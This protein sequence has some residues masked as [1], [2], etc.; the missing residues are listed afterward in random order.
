MLFNKGR[1]KW[2]PKVNNFLN[3]NFNHT[4]LKNQWISFNARLI[5]INLFYHDANED[6]PI[7]K[8]FPS[9]RIYAEIIKILNIHIK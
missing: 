2:R 1:K 5:L 4:Y 3:F 7:D 9:K 8:K 6:K